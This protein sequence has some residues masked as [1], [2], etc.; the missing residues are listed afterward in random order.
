MLINRT[1][2]KLHHPADPLLLA[3][4][5]ECGDTFETHT[6]AHPRTGVAH[7]CGGVSAGAVWTLL[8]APEVTR[9][10][11]AHR[12]DPNLTLEQHLERIDLAARAR[13]IARRQA[14]L[15]PVPA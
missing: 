13:A 2:V 4:C 14:S 3:E 12:R 9:A 7:R 10:R 1:A 8:E 11:A 5:V 15:A 6:P